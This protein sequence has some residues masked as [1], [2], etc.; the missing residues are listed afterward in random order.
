VEIAVKAPVWRELAARAR[1][2]GLKLEHRRHEA[3][4]LGPDGTPDCRFVSWSYSDA[5]DAIILRT[6]VAATL[7]QLEQHR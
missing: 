5:V 6:A 2:L 1:F 4:I 3:S 7:E